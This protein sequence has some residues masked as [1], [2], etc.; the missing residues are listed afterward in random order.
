[1]EALIL[2]AYWKQSK[3][4]KMMKCTQIALKI[5]IVLKKTIY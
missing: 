4:L 3:K 2:A 5:K 1:M